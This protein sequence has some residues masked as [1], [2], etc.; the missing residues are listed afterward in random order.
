MGNRCA[1][2]LCFIQ[3]CTHPMKKIITILA[4]FILSPAQSFSQQ[5]LYVKADAQG[6]GNGLSWANAMP[7][8][9]TAIAQ[10]IYG[11]EIRVAAG[12]YRPTEGTN[13][14][15][16]FQLLNG[17]RLRGGFAGQ[18]NNPDAQD[19]SL[20]H[21]ILSGDIGV[22]G[23]STDNAFSV[24]TAMGDLD[25]TTLL[26]GLIIEKGAA[27]SQD[28]NDHFSNSRKAGGGIF[29]KNNAAKNH[30]RVSNCVFRNNVAAVPGAHVYIQ[31]FYAQSNLRFE[32][33]AFWDGVG[34][35][36]FYFYGNVS[37]SIYLSHC[38]FLRN[39]TSSPM[40]AS[41]TEI[42]IFDKINKVV[43]DNCLFADNSVGG[44]GVAGRN[45]LGVRGDT[46]IVKNCM[47]QSN[48]HSSGL[49]LSAAGIKSTLVKNDT[50]LF[51]KMAQ[52]FAFNRAST[53][54][55][56][57][58]PNNITSK[59]E[60]CI[61]EG[62][63]AYSLC[64]PP[65]ES[66]LFTRCVFRNNTLQAGLFVDGGT[67]SEFRK[68]V[69]VSNCHF[70]KNI[71][72]SLVAFETYP[73]GIYPLDNTSWIFNQNFFRDNTGLLFDT[74]NHNVTDNI[75][76]AAWN[77]CTFT[78]NQLPNGHS[79][80]T[81]PFL[82]HFRNIDSVTFNACVFDQALLDTTH[83]FYDSLSLIQVKNCLFSA[84]SCIQTYTYGNTV[85]CDTSNFW[86]VSSIFQDKNANDFRLEACSPG[87]NKGNA[88]LTMQL[89]LLT[90]FDL[91]N[92]IENGVPDIGAFENKLF[93]QGA[94]SS[95]SCHTPA[96]G[97]YAPFGNT[98]GPYKYLWWNGLEG[99]MNANSLSEGDYQFT[100]TDAHGIVYFDTL[101]IPEFVQ[102]VIDTII[103]HPSNM[104]SQD[105]Q[106]QIAGIN[107]GQAPFSIVWNTGDTTA[108]LSG[109]GTGFYQV[110]ITDNLGCET[111]F[112]FELKAA[113]SVA[114]KKENK[115]PYLIPN[116][117]NIGV[118]PRLV[119]YN[120]FTEVMITNA[121]GNT[122]FHDKLT[123]PEISL[124]SMKAPGVY[125]VMAKDKETKRWS[126]PLPLVVM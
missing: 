79:G 35:S 65:N 45:I 117:I 48:T 64:G 101:Y 2:T 34:L 57:G 86:G 50:F 31:Q 80:D 19:P 5:I 14:D 76:T 11:T 38:S 71:Y 75:S 110:T 99:G 15:S 105:G 109:I 73:G 33:C 53:F 83:L 30:L 39:R 111:V 120:S 69:T 9:Q 97:S 82:F 24:I 32:N 106:I 126:K 121:L 92:R 119:G 6:N 42:N 72:R 96:T 28:P 58:G 118:Q 116:L 95:Y 26:E 67:Y 123:G 20:H 90:D 104:M 23:D 85:I 115:Q 40:A 68:E 78:G 41:V 44:L 25:E 77:Y 47:F 94:V 62:N 4:L 43:V 55:F 36:S 114:E 81:L 18:G 1:H 61:F 112:S 91:N 63:E 37:D 66:C 89:G 107:N 22:L 102:I 93:L 125:W 21:S 84:E 122:V 3:L 16:S 103:Q 46:I 27:T 98:C 100:I 87:I 70:E 56:S 7:N 52:G 88:A 10:A 74:R 113:S 29:I 12:I 59:M 13:R 60:D 17:I 124:P 49:V 51:N 8:L 54:G 108:S